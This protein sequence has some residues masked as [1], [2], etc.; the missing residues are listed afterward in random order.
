MSLPITSF[1]GYRLGT[2]SGNNL[3]LEGL[4]QVLGCTNLTL[5]Q[6]LK[7]IIITIESISMFSVRQKFD[8]HVFVENESGT[9]KYIK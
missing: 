5:A 7:E 6:R 3:P 4:N 2:I 9:G 8:L 1:M